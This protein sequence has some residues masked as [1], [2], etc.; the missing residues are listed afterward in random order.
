MSRRLP[1]VILFFMHDDRFIDNGI[2]AL[3]NSQALNNCFKSAASIL[4]D[5]DIAEIADARFLQSL[6]ERAGDVLGRRMIRSDPEILG[7]APVFAGTRVPV[8]A[9]FDYLEAGDSLDV[10]LEGFP[11]VRR[12]QAVAVLEAACSGIMAS[13]NPSG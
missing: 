6:L 10:F 3:R 4:S 1:K 7:G 8:Q 12:E 11:T 2:F 13:A 5:L 9:L